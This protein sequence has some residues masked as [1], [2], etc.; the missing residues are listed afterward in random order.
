MKTATSNK[1][2]RNLPCLLKWHGS[3]NAFQGK[4]ARWIIGLM[5]PHLHYVEAFAG[6]LAVLLAKNPDGVSEVVNDLDGNLLNFWRVMADETAFAKFHRRV[7]AVPFSE[8][9]WHD[10]QETEDHVGPVDRAVAFFVQ[11]RQSLAGRMDSFAAIT[12]NRTRRGMNEQA[13]AWLTAMEG[14][15]AVHERLKR[16]VIFGPKD[17]KE[18]IQQQDGFIYSKQTR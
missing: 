4:L 7:Q 1:P 14:L 10:A 3:K 18:V 6:G 12:R 9:H 17:A 5:P 15:P 11:C 2:T 16:V 8:A 13:S